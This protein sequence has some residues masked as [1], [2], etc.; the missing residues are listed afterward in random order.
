MEGL[1][2]LSEIVGAEKRPLSWVLG[3]QGVERPQ[4][5]SL[6]DLKHDERV[7]V[8]DLRTPDHI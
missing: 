1:L 5:P 7:R 4:E 6:R 8:T 2:L 3:P